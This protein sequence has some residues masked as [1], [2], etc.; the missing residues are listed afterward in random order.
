MSRLDVRAHNLRK[1]VGYYAPLPP[2]NF[3]A[4][5][6]YRECLLGVEGAKEGVV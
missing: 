4:N 5:L 6:A 3:S 1:H 2:F